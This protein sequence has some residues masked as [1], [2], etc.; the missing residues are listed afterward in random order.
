MPINKSAYRRYK[1]IDACLTNSMR[2]HPNM[3]DLQQACW[4]KLDIWPAIDTIQ[5]DI[6][7][8]KL[9]HPDGF[10]APIKYCRRNNGYEYKDSTFSIHKTGLN[11]KDIDSIKESIDLIQSIGSSRVGQSFSH[12][13][14]KVLSTYKESFPSGDTKRKIIQTDGTRS[15]QGFE[16]FDLLFTA[17]KDR[18]PV[19][20][21]HFSYK[22]RTFNAVTV[23]PTLLKE[24]DNRW[25]VVGHSEHHNSIR[26]FG[27]DRIYD[28]VLLRKE[29]IKAGA[30]KYNSYFKDVYGVYPIKNEAKQEIIIECSALVTNYFQAYPI[31]ESQKIVKNERGDSEIHFELIPSMELI[32][33]FRSYANQLRVKAPLWMYDHIIKTNL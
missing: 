18:T 4:E 28:P 7:N 10:D 30:A 21:V 15:S 23:H 25:Y 1:V 29:F 13:M 19:S 24:F 8:M 2:R 5:K 9:P 32:R 22:K 20:F 17:C 33:L 12:A 26:T 3:E 11:A 16:H 31:H 14:E 27:L 6:K